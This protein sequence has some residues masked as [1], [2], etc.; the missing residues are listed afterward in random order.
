MS[1]P[2][3]LVLIDKP[4]GITSHDAVDAVRRALGTRKVGHAG[5]LDPMATG[6]LVMGVGRGTRFLRFLAELDKEYEGIGRLG[7]ETDTLDAEGEVVRTADVDVDEAS[8][9][10]AMGALTGEIEQRPPAHSAVKVGGE[11]LYKAA[12]RG[13]VVAAPIRRVRVESFELIRFEPPDFDFRV[14]CSSGTYVR[15]LM[16]DVG[17][18]LGCGAHLTH[19]VRTRIGP[20]RRAEA[21]APDAVRDPLPIERAV[22]HLPRVDLEEEEVRAARHGRPLGPSGHDGPHAVFDPEGRLIGVWE[23][24][25]SR[26]RPHVVLAGG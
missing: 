13:E 10:E 26:S 15:S 21:A 16:A 1:A 6:L 19:L 24:E 12:R 7:V 2:E 22:A 9:R 5:T 3:G 14:I 23:D 18:R 25:G 17:V 20:Y 4:K 11:R 8:L